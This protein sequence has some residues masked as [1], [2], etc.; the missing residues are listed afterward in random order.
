MDKRY[1][2]MR[3]ADTTFR[4]VIRQYKKDMG[5]LL[6]DVCILEFHFMKLLFEKDSPQPVMSIA[7]E[8]CVSPSV[9]TANSNKLL[10]KGLICRERAATDK[11]VVE[12]GLTDKGKNLLMELE[13]KQ[14]DY[15]MNKFEGF[16]QKEIETMIA[17]LKRLLNN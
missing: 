3:D 7:N 17:Q 12:L 13:K 15:L 11:R 9:I 5:K 16:S 6:E 1:D 8:M 14:K 4:Q 10:N 2:L